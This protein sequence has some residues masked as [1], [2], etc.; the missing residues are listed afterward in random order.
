M[1]FRTRLQLAL[2]VPGLAAIALTG[3]EASAG[4]TGALQEAT[5][6][7]LTVIRDTRAHILERYFEDLR[8]HVV[9]LSRD[10]SI[11]DAVG[12]MRGAWERLPAPAPAAEEQLRQYYE[13]EFQT[14]LNRLRSPAL[15]ASGWLPPDARS[16]TLQ[17]AYL[18]T[19]PHPVGAKDLL[20]SAEQSREYDEL[21]ARYHPM[22]SR[23]RSAF[24]FYDIFLL[25][26]LDGRVVYSVMKET[27]L[28]VS[29][30]DDPFKASNL[31]EA[32][33]KALQL[34][35]SGDAVLV[36]YAPYAA[37]Y[38]APAA[39]AA[40]PI[41]TVGGTVGVL[42]IQ[43]SISEV[44]RVMSGDENWLAEGLGATGHA[45]LVGP[46][47]MLRSDLRRDAERS[48]AIA[49]RLERSGIAPEIL[50]TANTNG[51]GVLTLPAAPEV[52]ALVRT[53]VAGNALGT[54]W[55]GVPVIRSFT[56]LRLAGL[57]WTVVAEMDRDEAFAPV[58]ALRRRILLIGVGIGAL[59][60]FTGAGLA[61]TVTKPIL[62]L[63]GVAR[64]FGL[65]DLQARASHQSSDEIGQLSAAFNRMGEDLRSTMVSKQELEVLAGRLISTQEE[66]RMR[67]ARE[68]H[69]DFS[70]RLAAV[71][72]DAGRLEKSVEGGAKGAAQDLKRKMAD[73]ANDV[74]S[75]SRRLHPAML[76]DLGLAAAVE[77]E[78]RTFVERGGP[79]V[80]IELG[81]GLIDLPFDVQLA[82][83]RIVQ[84]AL[85]NTIR[86]ADA[87]SVQ[88][89]LRRE[90]QELALDITDDGRGFARNSG[91]WRAGVGL[92][93]MEE[94]TRLLGGTLVIESQ[95]GAGTH[96][97]MRLPVKSSDAT[98]ATDSR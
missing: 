2:V 28:G 68:L 24:G 87:G 59:F 69:D 30:N 39:F 11:V 37:S 41:R 21:H 14:R 85:R 3:W 7:R 52:A 73:L 62:A 15:P 78:C 16:R 86:H 19:N 47:V 22:L 60:L 82:A 89:Q 80:D 74:H 96:V 4:A 18:A 79:V 35:P 63:A 10:E 13:Q 55:G 98:T 40:A 26:A 50:Q 94:R 92:A 91:S 67:V 12:Q 42:A 31:A 1:S 57:S 81:D 76:D 90:G 83:Y 8:K 97:R 49:S 58:A 6:D 48:G 33:R 66:E 70:Q 43:V 61:A 93:S 32:Y 38:F 84:E 53:S 88:L 45:Y 20:L 17:A 36:D 29:L 95:P 75:L 46:D 71:A 25:S 64:R 77:A 65:G 27:D 5:V 56:P 44:N 34:A 23:Y 72:I 51:T 54:T 9:A